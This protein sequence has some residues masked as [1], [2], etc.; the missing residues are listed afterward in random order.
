MYLSTWT[1]LTKAQSLSTCPVHVPYLLFYGYCR[2]LERQVEN[3]YRLARIQYQR[4]VSGTISLYS[5]IFNTNFC[6]ISNKI[7]LVTAWMLW[8]WWFFRWGKISWKC[9]QDISRGGNFHETASI[10]LK[11]YWFYFR[12]GII[13]PVNI[14]RLTVFTAELIF[15]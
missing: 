15:W 11:S 9:H 2:K 3:L 14:S 8:R 5:V 13:F 12:A 4:P 7:T 6:D 10:S 1:L